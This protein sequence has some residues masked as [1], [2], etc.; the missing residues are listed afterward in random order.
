M[1]GSFRIYKHLWRE[2]LPTENELQ[3]VWRSFLSD[4]HSDAELGAFD[5]IEPIYEHQVKLMALPDRP[6]V[7]LAKDNH[8]DDFFRSGRL[9]LGSF[10]YYSSYEHNEVGDAQEGKVTAVATAEW[11]FFAG[12]YGSG[13]DNYVFCAFCGDPDDTLRR[14]LGY[15]SGFII[16]DPEGFAKAIQES[17]KASSYKYGMCVY[18][19]FKAIMGDNAQKIDRSRISHE[20]G[21]MITAAKHFIKPEKYSHQKEFRFIWETG[22]DINNAEVIECPEAVKFCRKLSA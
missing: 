2:G 16:E 9:Q 6:I 11:G 18:S 4:F 17:V 15:N 1:T 20:T 12:N 5:K 8:V 19:P 10:E 21:K 14:K 13:Y 3:I 22:K 7:K